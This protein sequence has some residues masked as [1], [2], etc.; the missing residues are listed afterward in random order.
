L[1]KLVSY[2][3]GFNDAGNSLIYGDFKAINAGERAGIDPD[4]PFGGEIK[5]TGSGEFAA[6][7]SSSDYGLYGSKYNLWLSKES[8]LILSEDG[9]PSS[10]ISV[11]CNHDSP[12]IYPANSITKV[13]AELMGLV[14]ANNK[15]A[16]VIFEYGIPPSY[17]SKIDAIPDFVDG[18]TDMQI[19][20]YLK[21]LEPFTTYHYRIKLVS[22]EGEFYSDDLKFYTDLNGIFFNPELIYGSVNDVDGNV[23]KT[24]AIGTQ[25]WL[26]ENLRTTRY[27]DG[28]PVPLVKDQS[29]WAILSSPGR[30]W[31]NNDSSSYSAAYGALY[32]WYNLKGGN[33][34]PDGWHV[35]TVDEWMNLINYLGVDRT[36]AANKLKEKGYTH[37]VSNGIWDSVQGNIATNESGFSALPAGERWSEF[38]DIGLGTEW[39]AAPLSDSTSCTAFGINVPGF[40]GYFVQD[41][42]TTDKKFGFSI[43]CLKN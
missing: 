7:W 8:V 21:D 5:F 17:E 22:S 34:C 33:I 11:R 2:L 9:F 25:I 43:R 14:N 12:I 40:Y 38:Y 29:E 1:G 13:S 27:N 37:W 10:S 18:S 35:P 23:Y 28:R 6:W 24:I 16:K 19:I 41:N 4:S 36:A 20:A 42:Y 31:Y 26:A 32:N 3:G 30:C 39:W 15:H